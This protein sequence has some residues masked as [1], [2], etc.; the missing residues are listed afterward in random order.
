M[1]EENA[2]KKLSRFSFTMAGVMM[3]AAIGLKTLV[4]TGSY[5][6]G[7]AAGAVFC[8]LYAIVFRKKI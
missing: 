5:Q 6:I 1:H 2:M 4:N 3:G 8:I 7:L